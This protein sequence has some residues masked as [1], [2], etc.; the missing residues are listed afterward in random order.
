MSVSLPQ[1]SSPPVKKAIRS[2]SKTTAG[3]WMKKVY[4]ESKGQ[5]KSAHYFV[6]LQVKGERRKM[7]LE[8][9]VKEEAAREAAALY[10]KVLSVGW[11]LSESAPSG[12]SE[13]G[14]E[15]LDVTATVT[16]GAWIHFA[17]K[18]LNV[19]SQTVKAY[20]DS[21]RTIASEILE[22]GET[23]KLKKKAIVLASGVEIL[24]K[25]NVQKWIE[26]RM[27]RAKLLDPVQSRRAH[28]T[29]RTLVGNAKGLFGADLLEADDAPG[30]VVRPLPFHEVK[31]PPKQVARYSSRFDANI[32]LDK[33]RGEL[34]ALPRD[35]SDT[36][37]VLRF[38][39][40]KILY[41][42]LV[43]GLR[44]SEIDR[45]RVEDVS[46]T[47]GKIAIR[48]HEGFRPKTLASEGEVPISEDAKHAIS[49]MLE[50][51]EGGWFLK[52]NSSRRFK[53]YRAGL[54]H[55]RLVAWL[56]TYEERGGTPFGDVSKPIHELRKEAGTLVNKKHGLAEAKN[57][58]RHSSIATTASYYVGS[59]GDI[60]T[61]LA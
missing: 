43:A 39:E 5:W 41:M 21:L 1:P 7:R 26:T 16:L 59:K 17:E 51:S 25:A 54:S 22:L 57:F 29:I 18:K 34:S 30:I 33:A 38:E 42:A 12:D 10:A 53:N 48:L 15:R 32:L 11:P 2:V 35:D 52:A 56:R 6:R 46:V 40:W 19:R 47:T 44:Y 28:N 23:P 9:S 50:H 61:G 8:S 55:D 36:E 14:E 13:L 31:L 3:Y 49:A 45:L 4:L 37:W 20:S 24:T 27:A 60:T 58:L